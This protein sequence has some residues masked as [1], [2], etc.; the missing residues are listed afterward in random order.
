MSDKRIIDLEAKQTL[1]SGDYLAADSAQ[2]TYKVDANT[3]IMTPLT[4]VRN[5][6]ANSSASPDKYSSSTAYKVGDMVIQ[7]DILYKCTTACSAASW[8]VNSACFTATTLASVV[9][10]LNC[11]LLKINAPEFISHNIP[12]LIPKDISAYIADGSFW[13]RLNGT[14]GYSLFEDI[15]V[16][17]YVKMSRAITAPDQ[18]SQYAT[19]GSQYITLIGLDTR[20]GDGDGGDSVSVINYHH[21]IW[22]AGQGFGGTQHFGRKR[23]NSS[24]V[25]TGGYVNSE[26]FTATIGSAVSSGSI[27]SGATINQ[28]LYAEFGSH[29]KKTRELLTN[30]MESTRYNRFGQASGASSGWAWT[31]CQAVLMSEVEVYG[32]T[33]WSSSGYDTGNANKQFPL[34]AF[35]KEAMNNRSAWYWLKDVASGT[36]FC[37]CDNKGFSACNAASYAYDYVRPRF[38][39]A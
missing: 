26:M 34:F 33:V 30:A 25:T 21:S 9:T 38:I 37:Y 2:G 1:G 19:T 32:S 3:N 13:N 23:M 36:D 12:R 7:N 31:T 27:A 22:T 29:L 14:G 20:M 17:D 24:N 10:Q 8:A 15:F 35:N 18:D 6:V 28:Q 5:N 11:D 16:G 4:N 39:L